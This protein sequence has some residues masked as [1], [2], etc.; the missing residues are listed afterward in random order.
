M[1]A[2]SAKLRDQINGASLLV[3]IKNADSWSCGRSEEDGDED[4]DGD[5]DGDSPV[6]CMLTSLTFTASL[7]A[8]LLM[9]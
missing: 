6:C 3:E 9:F 7:N 4:E 8:S 5:G 1:V 2:G